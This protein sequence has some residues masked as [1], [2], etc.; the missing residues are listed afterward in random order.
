[1]KATSSTGNP[2]RSMSST[3]FSLYWNIEAVSP[4]LISHADRGNRLSFDAATIGSAFH[5]FAYEEAT[6]EMKRVLKPG[7]LVYI[8]QYRY[9]TTEKEEDHNEEAPL[10][11]CY[12]V[13]Y[14]APERTRTTPEFIK[15]LLEMS[16]FKNVR[17]RTIKKLRRYSVAERVGR[18]KTLSAYTLLSARNKKEVTTELTR[19]LE[20]KWGGRKYRLI[21]QSIDVLYGYKSE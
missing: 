9:P 14:P 1:M 12:G 15:D 8:F 21:P 4:C 13:E 2:I 7:G 17:L 18:I 11:R 16:G 20:R 10:L 19:I 3:D 6:V 5:W